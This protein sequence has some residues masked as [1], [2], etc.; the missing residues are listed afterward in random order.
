VILRKT[1]VNLIN[2]AHEVVQQRT[3]MTM[4][5]NLHVKKSPGISS[6]ADGLPV[7]QVVWP[8]S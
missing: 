3:H 8:W 6:P 7:V 5:K 4:I 1:G 2:L